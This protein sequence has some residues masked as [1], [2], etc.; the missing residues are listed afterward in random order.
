MSDQLTAALR[1]FLIIG[2]LLVVAA[3]IDIYRRKK[4]PGPR[5]PKKLIRRDVFWAI[6]IVMLLV[7]L[8]IPLGRLS[9]RAPQSDNRP[10]PISDKLLLC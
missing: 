2:A 5:E 8:G 3:F 9:T 10:I 4:S 1:G 6:I 7:L